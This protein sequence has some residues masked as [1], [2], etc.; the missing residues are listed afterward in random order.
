MPAIPI[1]ILLPLML[2]LVLYF[3]PARQGRTIKLIPVITSLITLAGIFYVLNDQA[4]TWRL[5]LSP[6][7][8]AL[9][10]SISHYLGFTTEGASG[11]MLLFFGILMVV[12][13]FDATVSK[14]WSPGS[15]RFFVWFLFS[16]GLGFA[17]LTSVH[18]YTLVFLWGV[19]AIPFYLLA[20]GFE[21]E[22]AGMGKKTMILFGASHG[23]MAIGAVMAVSLGGSAN[24]TVLQLETT[25]PYTTVSFLFL[26]AGGFAAAGIFPI[27]SWVTPYARFANGQSF[28]LMPLVFQRFAGTY[29]LI[30]LCHDLFILSE[31]MRVI[32]FSFGFFSSILALL[33]TFAGS[34]TKSKLGN[35]H[36][37]L[38]GMVLAGIATG[39][40]AGLASALIY[41]LAG[42]AA[43]IPFFIVPAREITNLSQSGQ[44]SQ[45]LTD[46]DKEKKYRRKF[47]LSLILSGVPPFG[48]FAANILL[49]RGL[50]EYAY[51]TGTTGGAAFLWVLPAIMVAAGVFVSALGLEK[52]DQEETVPDSPEGQ[53]R[54]RLSFQIMFAPIMVAILSGFLLFPPVNQ[55]VFSFTGAEIF[56][57]WES[58]YILRAGGSFLLSLGLGGM[59]YQLWPFRNQRLL[60]A[61][62]RL[63]ESGNTDI[64]QVFSRVVFAIN[65]P[66]SRIHDGVL[67]TYLVWVVITIILLLWLK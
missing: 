34:Q 61:L 17:I 31:T 7:Y 38:G 24:I 50:W 52:T 51:T 20:S 15:D 3:F 29:L 65:R 26:L 23:F 57:T 5:F 28:A 6:H 36:L 40:Q 4:L 49:F 2:S 37:A 39:T 30:R 53:S 1:I 8:P 41:V 48:I 21:E 54:G 10:H 42:G 58:R 14:N 43:M 12:L 64:Y 67:Q 63:E 32:L 60:S 66:L 33:L 19:S 18:L 62:N 13:A 35:L 55:W 46:F 44:A 59:L 27:H 16:A 56:V 25:T 9:L 47:F 45:S 22:S 11:V